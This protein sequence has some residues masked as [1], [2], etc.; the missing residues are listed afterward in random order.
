MSTLPKPKA[1]DIRTND[2]ICGYVRILD[3]KNHII[4]TT[5]LQLIITFYH[6]IAR[7]IYIDHIDNAKPII[8]ASTLHEDKICKINI[9]LLNKSSMEKLNKSS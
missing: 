1:V 3:L 6:I 9:K 4:P 7:I 5:I 2:L 8:Y